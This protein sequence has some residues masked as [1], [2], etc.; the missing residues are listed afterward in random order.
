MTIWKFHL[1]LDDHV[2]ITMPTGARVLHVGEQGGEMKLWALVDPDAEPEGRHFY[3]VGTGN[4]AAHIINR[5]HV[6]TALVPPF[7]WHVFEEAR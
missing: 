6:G 7:V 3:I 4:P 2:R 1:P 5:K